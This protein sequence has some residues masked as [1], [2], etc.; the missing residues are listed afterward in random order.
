MQNVGLDESQVGI[1]IARRNIKRLRYANG[2][3][4]MAKS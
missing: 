3:T 2:A 4:L 1:E